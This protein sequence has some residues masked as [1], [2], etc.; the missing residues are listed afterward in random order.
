MKSKIS[1]K[2]LV[3]NKETIA[4]LDN[5]MLKEFYGGEIPEDTKLCHFPIP[6]SKLFLY[7]CP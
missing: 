3:L 1:S 7:C 5:Q 6:T 4:E 2:K